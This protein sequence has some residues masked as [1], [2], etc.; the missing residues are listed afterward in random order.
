MLS[1]LDLQVSVENQPILN[2]FS[3]EIAPGTVH[4]IMGPNVSG[5]STLAYTLLGHPAYIVTAG[6]LVFENQD[7]LL[8]SPDKRAQLGIFLAFQHPYSVPGVTVFAL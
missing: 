8:L 4:A 1:V 2:G 3:L 5:K 6:S 7:L